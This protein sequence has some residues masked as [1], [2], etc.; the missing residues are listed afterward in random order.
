MTK[1]N[2]DD[3]DWPYLIEAGA[4][5]LDEAIRG[6][7]VPLFPVNEEPLVTLSVPS[8]EAMS[9]VEAVEDFIAHLEGG[10]A[11]GY[12][13]TVDYG[14]R[15]FEVDMASGPLT[16]E[17]TPERVEDRINVIVEL[18]ANEVDVEQID[19]SD[20]DGFRGWLMDYSAVVIRDY[21]LRDTLA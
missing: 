11:H 7:Y 6:G 9:P 16:R 2:K 10:N 19:T 5:T 12:V 1:F 14:S 20:E 17:V 13:Y 18:A 3:L 15:A 21:L 4:V 8:D